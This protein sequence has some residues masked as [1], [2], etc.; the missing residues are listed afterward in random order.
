[1]AKGR[2]SVSDELAGLGRYQGRRLLEGDDL[3]LGATLPTAA[4]SGRALPE[5]LRR[6]LPR[7]AVARVLPGLYAH[8]LCAESATRFY[9]EEWIVAS[10]SD[11]IGYRLKGGSPLQFQPWEAPFGAGDD[12]SNIVDAGYPIG[13]IQVS[14]GKEPII[15]LRDAVSGGG[16]A[17]VGTVIRADLDVAAHCSSIR[18]LRLAQQRCNKPCRPGNN[19]RL[20]C[21]NYDWRCS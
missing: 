6:S 11:R 4:Q 15:L 14:A 2:K 20:G 8:R 1:M 17:M 18:A 9:Q 19:I 3:V 13:S 21:S 12:P 10:E 16:Y 5:S 7:K